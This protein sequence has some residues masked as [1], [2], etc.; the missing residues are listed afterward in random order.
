MK[1]TEVAEAVKEKFKDL[2]SDV[3]FPREM[4]VRLSIPRESI[5]PFCRFLRDELSCEHLSLVTAVDWP[6]NFECVYHIA[7]YL[8]EY[9]VELHVK[10]PKDDPKIDSLSEVWR[11]ADFPER[12]AY[13]MMGITFVGHPDLRRILL[14]EDYLFFPLRK[15]FKG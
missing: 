12:E 10:I 1:G 6:D 4:V 5:V 9:M 14:P 11:G 2:V 3:S 7:S 8:E 13:D 15:D